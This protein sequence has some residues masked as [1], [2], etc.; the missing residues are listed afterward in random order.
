[1]LKE[2]ILKVLGKSYPPSTMV[3]Q[4]QGRYDLAFKTDQEGRPILLFI[5][6]KEENGNIK[7]E[8]Y[9]RRMVFDDKGN[10]LKDHW[11]NKGK[12]TAKP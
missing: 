3:E 2:K 7:G 10:I 1:M 5:G 11:D 6:Q 4:R 12:A 9:A 8:R